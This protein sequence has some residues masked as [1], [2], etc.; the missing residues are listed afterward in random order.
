MSKNFLKYYIII[1]LLLIVSGA[2]IFYYSLPGFRKY[3]LE[4]D[5]AVWDV[6]DI[7][8]LSPTPEANLIRYGRELIINTAKYLG[9]KGVIA[10]ISN[11]MNCENCHLEAGTRL[12][13]N[14]FAMVASTYPKFRERSGRR[15]SVEFR[16]NECM[17]RSLNG[18]RLDSLSKEMKAMKAYIVWLGKGVAKDLKLKG[19]GIPD[20]TLLSRAA[21][22]GNGEQVYANKCTNCHA[23]NGE[24]LFKADSSAY[25]YPPLWGAHSYNVSAGIYRLSRLAGYIKYNMPFTAVQQDPVLSD[26]EAWDVA[27]YINS[28]QRP[29]KFFTYDWPK[30]AAKPYDFPFGPYA[31]GFTALQHKYGPFEIIKN[32]IKKDK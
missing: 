9:P 18:E 23:A 5:P 2:V 29:E 15:E 11:G 32:Q 25:F 14:C 19:M 24:G 21:S 16:I 4:H 12:N 3:T 10:Q 7:D 31:D 17:E 8:S 13:G 30:I 6:P 28:Q 22:I 26:E 20:I 1:G 27:A